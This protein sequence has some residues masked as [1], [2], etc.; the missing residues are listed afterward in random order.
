M[1]ELTIIVVNRNNARW[2]DTCFTSINSQSLETFDL[3]FID[4][5]S[6]DDSLER[7]EKYPW[8]RGV[9]LKSV[10]NREQ[11]GVSK[12]RNTGMSQ[13][14]TKYVTQIDSDDFLIS[15]D[16]L[17]RE[18]EQVKRDHCRIV[19]SRIIQV[20]AEGIALPKQSALPVVEGNLK[21]PIFTRSC[22]IPRDFTLPLALFHEAGGYD[23]DINLYEDWD[24]K[25]RLA[26]CSSYQYSGLD[27]IAY[28]RHGLG[29][30]AV[31][32]YRHKEAQARVI[33]KN[34]PLFAGDLT[35]SEL[36]DIVKQLGL[37]AT[38]SKDC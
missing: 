11:L 15:H 31:D 34:L 12:K 2:L 21:K 10:R 18:L 27:G 7:F 33:L 24:L 29:L 3:I 30:S 4:D 23:P 25:I 16:K 20:D 19:F 28:R 13:V 38:Q 6:T 17:K 26:A 9:S 35:I 32:K 1:N 37:T 5:C 22:M 36:T 8:R 14:K